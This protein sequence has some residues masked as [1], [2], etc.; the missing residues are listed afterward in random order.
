MLPWPEEVFKNIPPWTGINSTY[1]HLVMQLFLR[2][3]HCSN[4][5]YNCTTVSILIPCLWMLVL[6]HLVCLLEH[7]PLGKNVK[8]NFT[9][10]LLNDSYAKSCCSKIISM[11]LMF[12]LHD[13][14]HVQ[15]LRTTAVLVPET[16]YNRYSIFY[17]A[18]FTCCIFYTRYILSIFG[19]NKPLILCY[20]IVVLA[21]V[22]E[23][24]IIL[25]IYWTELNMQ[26]VKIAM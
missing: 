23:H 1:L 21:Y 16:F 15:F 24:Y 10:F 17:I 2:P 11:T 18:I 19:C 3:W 26:Q 13:S 25:V 7:F 4:P 14:I 20:L 9:R 22:G 8:V 6:T 5:F 12:W